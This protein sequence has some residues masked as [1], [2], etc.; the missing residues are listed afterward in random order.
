MKKYKVYAKEEELRI[1][2]Q[3]DAPEVLL[4]DENGEQVGVI[5]VEEALVRSEKAELDLVEVAPN[6]KPPVCK[7]LDYSKY[8]YEK[9][10]KAKEAKKKQ[11]IIQNKEVRFRPNI[12]DHDLNTKVTKAREFL[13]DGDRVKITIMFRGRE[14][15]YLDRGPLLMTKIMSH[16]GEDVH[17]E[18]TPTMEGRFLTTVVTLKKGGN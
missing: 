6:A 16:L 3:I 8:K 15:A 2:E 4:V 7:L 5:P 13:D 14:M 1:N 17:M 11:K 12:E 9:A 10:K 18:Y